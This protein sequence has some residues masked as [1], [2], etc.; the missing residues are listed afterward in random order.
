MYFS[1][2]GGR[3][4]PTPAGVAG[5]SGERL[6]PSSQGSQV[7]LRY[8]TRDIHLVGDMVPCKDGLY[9]RDFQG[10]HARPF[11]RLLAHGRCPCSSHSSRLRASLARIEAASPGKPGRFCRIPFAHD[12][13]THCRMFDVART[14]NAAFFTATVKVAS[15]HSSDWREHTGQAI[16]RQGAPSIAA[17]ALV[18][19]EHAP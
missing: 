10:P 13:V 6:R 7:T 15:S 11:S 3:Q 12:P 8:I 14:Q 19:A 18:L 2:A 9:G 17:C 4:R 5:F 1:G 16:L